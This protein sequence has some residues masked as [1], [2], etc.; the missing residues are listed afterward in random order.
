MVKCQSFPTIQRIRLVFLAFLFERFSILLQ[1]AKGPSQLLDFFVIWGNFTVWKHINSFKKIYTVSKNIES[2]ENIE[3]NVLPNRFDLTH[4]S[5]W[6]LSLRNVMARWMV[7][8]CSKLRRLTSRIWSPRF[9]PISG[10]DKTFKCF[11]TVQ[12]SFD[13]ITLGL[14]VLNRFLEVKKT[15]LLTI[16]PPCKKVLISSLLQIH[17]KQI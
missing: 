15:E 10:K 11:A 16:L 9:K 7:M 14:K 5:R 4:I 1:N 17:T 6:V 12:K 3:K 13:F 2:F 8:V